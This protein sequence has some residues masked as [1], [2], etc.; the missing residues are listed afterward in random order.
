VAGLQNCAAAPSFEAVTGLSKTI[1]VPGPDYMVSVQATVSLDDG[2]GGAGTDYETA[3]QI[4]EGAVAVSGPISVF[5]RKT[6]SEN[7]SMHYV[8]NSPTAGASL[9]YT[10]ECYCPDNNLDFMGIIAGGQ[11]ESELSIMVQPK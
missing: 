9:A 5:I 4:K 3:C 10:V 6:T 7:V 2:S 11:T 1:I 8:N